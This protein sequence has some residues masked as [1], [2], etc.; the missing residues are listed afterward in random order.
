[1]T[2]VP[3]GADGAD[4]GAPRIVDNPAERRY[5]AWLGERLAGFA[6]YRLAG[7]R[8]IFFHTEIDPAFE[9]R[10]VGSRLAADALDDVRRRGLRLT[11]KC[12]FI[13]A[14]VKRHPD[15]ADLVDDPAARRGG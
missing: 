10:G 11:P 6:E 1:V 5:E 13:A 7:Q 12:P 14:F 9:G 3:A 2:S 4:T 15:Y 8:I